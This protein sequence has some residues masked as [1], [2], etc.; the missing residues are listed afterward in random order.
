MKDQRVDIVQGHR[1][2]I[3]KGLV[4]ESKTILFS[5]VL[6]SLA[7]EV[8]H[9]ASKHTHTNVYILTLARHTHTYTYIRT[10][11]HICASIHTHI[12]TY[13]TTYMHAYTPTYFL[14]L[15]DATEIRGKENVRRADLWIAF[16]NESHFR[17]ESSDR[18]WMLHESH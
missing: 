14:I 11:S 8:K 17:W 7:Q 6:Y 13:I 10:Y 5:S 16:Q 1:H 15:G 9:H 18:M 12:T 2:T 3:A 4:W